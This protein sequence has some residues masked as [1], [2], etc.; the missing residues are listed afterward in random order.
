MIGV[1]TSALQDIQTCV[2]AIF[3]VAAELGPLF[4]PFALDTL[5]TI[6]ALLDFKQMDTIRNVA[7]VT[8]PKLLMCLANEPQVASAKFC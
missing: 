3:N 1:N 8:L 7:A 6:A 5:D 2:Y 4:A